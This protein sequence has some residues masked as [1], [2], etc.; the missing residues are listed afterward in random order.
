METKATRAAAYAQEELARY[1]ATKDTGVSNMTWS[2]VKAEYKAS[3]NRVWQVVQVG[4]TTIK[5]RVPKAV[6]TKK[7]ESTRKGILTDAD[8]LAACTLD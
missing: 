8:V 6:G 1:R 5:A 3:D 2:Q 4:N 7:I